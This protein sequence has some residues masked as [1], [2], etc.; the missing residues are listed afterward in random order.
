M[1]FSREKIRQA[2]LMLELIILRTRERTALHA[3]APLSLVVYTIFVAFGLTALFCGSLILVD[4]SIGMAIAFFCIYLFCTLWTC[5]VVKGVFRVVQ[6]ALYAS[7]FRAGNIKFNS[8]EAIE[9]PH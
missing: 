9:E 1:I 6:A 8:T 5:L 4:D 3:V 7:A 2:A